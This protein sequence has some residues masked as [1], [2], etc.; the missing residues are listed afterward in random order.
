MRMNGDQ[1]RRAK[2]LVA[3][4]LS[5]GSARLSWRVMRGVRHNTLL[6]GYNLNNKK[7]TKMANSDKKHSFRVKAGIPFLEAEYK[8][9]WES[10]TTSQGIMILSPADKDIIQAER[11]E[12][13]H[14]KRPVRGKIS[15][16]NEK[17]LSH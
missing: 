13:H 1:E 5:L 8:T 17:R 9:E 6:T 3:V 14:L 7:G 11:T 2:K 16:L 15:G 10:A 12:P 4:S